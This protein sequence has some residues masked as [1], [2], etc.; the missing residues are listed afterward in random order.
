MTTKEESNCVRNTTLLVQGKIT[1]I[2][3]KLKNG[4]KMFT[5]VKL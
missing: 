4:K 5:K 1:S 3:K 2:K